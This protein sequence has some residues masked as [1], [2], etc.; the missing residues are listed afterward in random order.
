MRSNT[1]RNDRGTPVALALALVGAAALSAQGTDP[2]ALSRLLDQLSEAELAALLAKVKQPGGPAAAPAAAPSYPVAAPGY[3]R[4][5]GYAA[6]ARPSAED[7]LARLRMEVA[8]RDTS[9][10]ILRTLGPAGGEP[11]VSRIVQD[12]VTHAYHR[13]GPFEHSPRRG[14]SLSLGEAKLLAGKI[15]FEVENAMGAGAPFSLSPQAR[16]VFEDQILAATPQEPEALQAQVRALTEARLA[17]AAEPPRPLSDDEV[18]A[19]DAA[20]HRI[21]VRERRIDNHSSYVLKQWAEEEARRRRRE[22]VAE[23]PIAAR[24]WLRRN[25]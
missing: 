21:A 9:E 3:P 22:L 6:P 1:W 24:A 19:I 4:A 8:A 5:P 25:R 11:R 2:A 10:A 13:S 15:R 20:F 12:L 17:P 23:G 14:V 18:E 16:K 7:R